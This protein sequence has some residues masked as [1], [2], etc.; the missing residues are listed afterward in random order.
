MFAHKFKA[1][2]VTI[3]AFG[4]PSFVES[5]F[6]LVTPL[7]F[8]PHWVKMKTVKLWF[9]YFNL[10]LTLAGITIFRSNV[11]FSTMVQPDCDY[12]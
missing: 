5:S 7:S 3:C 12:V 8:V 2:I 11:I 10:R 4:V 9:L 6:G 1:P